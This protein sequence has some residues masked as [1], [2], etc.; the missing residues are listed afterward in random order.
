[1]RNLLLSGSVGAAIVAAALP[2]SVS[3]QTRVPVIHANVLGP[4][5]WVDYTSGMYSFEAKAPVTLSLE[6]ESR[7]ICVTGGGDYLDGRYYYLSDNDGLGGQY[8]FRLY[9]YDA[10]TWIPKNNFRMPGNWSAPDMATDPVT[11][12]FYGTFT[13]NR[14]IY[15]FGWVNPADGEFHDMGNGAGG[16]PV[17]GVNRYGAVYAI[18]RDGNLLSVNTADG[19]ATTLYAT[20]LVPA[21]LQTG[22]FDPM[23]ELFYWCYRD[24]EDKT[25]LYSLDVNAGGAADGVKL[26]GPFPQ[27]EL[28]FGAY[29]RPDLT[30]LQGGPAAPEGLESKASGAK[31]AVSFTLP[32]TTGAGESLTGK[33]VGYIVVADGVMPSAVAE[34]EAGSRVEMEFDFADGEHTV[35]VTPVCDGADGAPAWISFYVGPDTPLPVTSLTASRRGDTFVATWDATAG[36]VSGGRINSD[37]IE[38]EVKFHYGNMS[39]TTTVTGTTFEKEFTSPFPVNCHVEV[40]A[41]DGDLRSERATSLQVMMGTGYKLPYTADFTAGASTAEFLAFDANGDGVTWF[42]ESMDDDMRT[43]YKFDDGNMDDWLFT[44]ILM[45]DTDYFY[46]L[47]YDVHTAGMAYEERMEVKAGEGRTPTDMTVAISAPSTYTGSSFTTYE[48]YFTIPSDGNWSVG[49]HSVSEGQNLYIAL[50]NIVVER[51]G[52]M[53]A[54]AAVADAK[55]IPAAGGALKCN[56]SFTAPTLSVGGDPLEENMLVQLRSGNVTVAEKRDVAPGAA[57]LFEEVPSEQGTNTF[58][59]VCHNGDGAGM[60]TVVEAY[61][62]VDVPLPPTNVTVHIGSNGYPVVSW[63]APEGGAN[64][65]VVNPS[66]LRY[67][68]RRSLDKQYILSSSGETVAIDRLGLYGIEQALMY[69]QVYAINDAGTSVPA[70]SAHFTM[71][72]PYALPYSDSFKEMLEMHGPW[73]GLLLDNPKGCWYLDEEGTRPSCEPVDGDG[74]LVTFAPG[75][76]GHTAAM[77]TPLIDIDGADYPTL[78]FYLF[79]TRENDS[80]LDVGVRTAGTELETLRSIRLGDASLTPGWNMFRIPLVDYQGEEYVQVYFTGF[81]GE[82]YT[83]RIHIDHVGVYDIPRYDVEASLLEVPEVM[84]PGKEALFLATVTNTGIDQV[85]DIDVTLLR[86]GEPVFSRRVARLATGA[87]L[88]L[89]LSDTVD[90]S[91]ADVV[92]YSFSVASASDKN[93]ANDLSAAYEVAVDLPHYPVPELRGTVAGN[94]ATLEWDAPQCS[95]VRAPVADGFESYEPFIID[96]MGDW[97]L[98]DIDGKAGTTGILDGDGNELNYPNMGAAMAYQVF[99]PEHVG[100]PIYDEDGSRSMYAAHRGSHM[101]C[102]FSDLDAYNDDWLISPLLPGNEQVISFYAKSYTRYYGEEAFIIMVNRG[103]STATAD[104]SE[105]TEVIN[106]PD[107]WNRYEFTLPEGTRR[108]AIRCVSIDQFALCLDD[109]KFV[110]ESS[111]AV[112]LKI[113]GYNVYRDGVLAAYLPATATSWSCELDGVSSTSTFRVSALYDLGESVHSA[114]VELAVSGVE[115]V[116][117]GVSSEVTVRGYTGGISI[118][119]PAASVA[120]VYTTDGRLAAALTGSGEI[121]LPA[122]V[123]IVRTSAGAVKVVVR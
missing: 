44:P 79:C 116:S 56:V 115:S 30:A 92:N 20:G 82:E 67:S 68:V 29:I 75:E 23:G 7:F 102:A 86:E 2:L 114:P 81:A 121:A 1:M 122:A 47:R 43:N 27:N 104:F 49:F 39:E 54:P 63:S 87:K 72:T 48:N 77:A 96:N 61:T 85:E 8:D 91:S 25:A 99:N 26:I 36:G 71:G 103:E 55:V 106:T 89:D 100:F 60:P 78:E 10:D 64:G 117:G 37:A 15:R 93:S 88:T 95:G 40:V 19:S 119:Q 70:E 108:F 98:V 74:G 14:S 34:G 21:E 83:N 9:V 28:M 35:A 24:A 97:T 111:E 94:V 3:A 65:G 17:M 120:E 84:Q 53:T 118:K 105:L 58:E 31:T 80:R 22:C 6:K 113:A 110:P 16:Y 12:R 46:H 59:I 45:L 76:A 32:D 73:L 42:Y 101:L 41:V 112:D 57:V 11:G 33:T 62:G 69:Y 13:T 18:D 50:D 4:A 51:G 52:L 66:G 123:Y 38:Y 5:E 90:L 109:V 107:E